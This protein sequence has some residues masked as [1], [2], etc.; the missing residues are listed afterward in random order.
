MVT[1][2]ALEAVTD[3]LAGPYAT[4]RHTA[5]YLAARGLTARSKTIQLAA[6]NVIN[7]HIHVAAPFVESMLCFAGAES[8]AVTLRISS[9]TMDR[10]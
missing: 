9:Q 5:V 1:E 3:N 6:R 4:C 7:F 10:R 8:L 2:A